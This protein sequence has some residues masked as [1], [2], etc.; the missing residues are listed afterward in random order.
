[1]PDLNLEKPV[2]RDRP[3]TPTTQAETA[4]GEKPDLGGDER[5]EVAKEAAR[6]EDA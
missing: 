1:M 4:A 2:R 3:S 6:T 5:A